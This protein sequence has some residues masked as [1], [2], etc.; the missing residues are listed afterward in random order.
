[1]TM[2]KL[3]YMSEAKLKEVKIDVEKNRERYCSGDFS[4]LYADNG[5]NIESELV[6][7]DLDLLSTLDGVNAKAGTDI[8]SSIIVYKSLVGMT[9]ALAMEARVWTRLTHVECLD[10]SRAR[11]PVTGSEESQIKHVLIH[12]FALGRTGIRDDNAI[13]RLWWNMHIANIAEPSDPEGALRLMLKT[14][15]IRQAIVERPN[16]A[17]R[18]P[19]IRA[20]LRAIQTDHWITSTEDSFR[21]FMIELNINGGGLLF[22]VYSADSV[23]KVMLM[24]AEKARAYLEGNK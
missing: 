6:R 10:Y 18:K 4:D 13:S 11:W 7:L 21:R 2:A 9:P 8:E 23:D 20:L 14:A 22:E 16:T 15:D 1:M 5:W 12:F 19:L 24:C 17:S 3:M